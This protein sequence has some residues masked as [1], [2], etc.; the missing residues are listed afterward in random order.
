MGRPRHLQEH[1]ANDAAPDPQPLAD[2]PFIIVPEKSSIVPLSRSIVPLWRNHAPFRFNTVPPRFN[3]VLDR[4]NTVPRWRSIVSRRCNIVPRRFSIVLGCRNT[5]PRRRSH[6]PGRCIT[7]FR[8]NKNELREFD[9]ETFKDDIEL[10]KDE[11]EPMQFKAAKIPHQT[12]NLMGMKD[13]GRKQA[14]GPFWTAAGVAVNGE[15]APLMPKTNRRRTFSR[16][17]A[18]S[19]AP[20]RSACSRAR[21]MVGIEFSQLGIFIFTNLRVAAPGPFCFFPD[22]NR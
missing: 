16:A 13:L 20:P 15:M 2:R 17:A 10:P 14:F 4:L 1:D 12:E 21:R 18:L 7:V 19:P 5:V 9:I 11:I 3:I 8:T 22:A 6:V